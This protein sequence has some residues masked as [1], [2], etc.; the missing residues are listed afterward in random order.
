MRKSVDIPRRRGPSAR[1]VLMAAVLGMACVASG[2]QKAPPQDKTLLGEMKAYPFRII[3]E[4]Y[5]DG[6]WELL[7]VD[8][9]GGN[10]VNLTKTPKLQELYPQ[11]SP[12]GTK[13]CFVCDEGEGD[14]LIRNVYFMNIDGSGR[15]LVARNARQPCWK[16]DGK[17]IA[18]LKGEFE[19]YCCMDFATKGLFFYDLATGKHREHPNK[20]LHHLYNPC[21]SPDGKWFVAT[22]H[23]GMGFKHAILAIEADGQKVFNLGIHGCRPDFSPDGK[24]IAW[25]VSDWVLMA[26]DIDLSGPEPKLSHKRALVKSVKPTKIYHVDWSPDGKYVA[27]SRGPAKKRLGHAPEIVSIAAEGW[28]LCIADAKQASRW[29]VITS[30]RKCD[31]EPDWVPVGTRKP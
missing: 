11:V 17:T 14:A 8:A 12:D 4:T 29:V 24:H 20:K 18:Y 22:V 16:R 28:H 1:S 5:W 27:F 10:P 6:N 21:W 7:R 23:A 19:K 31:K 26:A 3:S 30:G 13:V 9:D 2:E 25:G 15:T